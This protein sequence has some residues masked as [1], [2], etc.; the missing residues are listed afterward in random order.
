[1]AKDLSLQVRLQA[2]DKIT[3]PL[4]KITKGSGKTAEAIR[5]SKDQLRDLNKQQ[6][7]VSAYRQTRWAMR[8]NQRTIDEMTE[9]QKE[10][11]KA[12]EG[13]RELRWTP[14]FGQVPKL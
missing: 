7:D 5:A 4:K 8:G 1:M 13:Q 10:Y 6:K 14:D 9:K 11:S 12:L 2:I 3:S